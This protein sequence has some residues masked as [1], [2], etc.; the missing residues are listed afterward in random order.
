MSSQSLRF[1]SDVSHSHVPLSD[2]KLISLRLR[3]S[4]QKSNIIGY[5]KLNNNILDDKKIKD[6]VKLLAKDTFER[7]EMNSI[8]KWEFFKFKSEKLQLK[9]AK[10]KKK[11]EN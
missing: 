10:N 2:H 11:K 6:G 3:G 4:N 1:V 8:Q 9:A 7:K 5:W